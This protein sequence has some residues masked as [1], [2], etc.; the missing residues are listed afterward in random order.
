M[1][2]YESGLKLLIDLQTFFRSVKYQTPELIYLECYAGVLAGE[3]LRSQDLKYS[4]L[5]MRGFEVFKTSYDAVRL[6]DV[7]ANI[8]RKFPLRGHPARMDE[9]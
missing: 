6:I 5:A 2:R 8:K 4:D 3:P 9:F 1:H 7:P